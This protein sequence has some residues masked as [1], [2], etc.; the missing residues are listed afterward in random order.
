[1]VVLHG[2]LIVCTRRSYGKWFIVSFY[3]VEFT[4]YYGNRYLNYISVCFWFFYR[5]W[6]V[7]QQ[8]WAQCSKSTY[9]NLEFQFQI[10]TTKYT[11]K[12][13]K[14]S[15][16]HYICHFNKPKFYTQLIFLII[17]NRVKNKYIARPLLLF[18]FID[19]CV[20]EMVAI[21]CAVKN[22][23]RKYSL[24]T[25]REK[26]WYFSFDIIVSVLRKW[27]MSFSGRFNVLSMINVSIFNRINGSYSHGL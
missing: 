1:M 22:W 26:N 23:N 6:R 27:Y 12:V 20:K 10:Y 14:S 18:Y 4:G 7:S 17:L 2:G 24:K 25:K 21:L 3:V 5:N 9:S 16:D 19:Q 8:W 15:L 11:L 13:M